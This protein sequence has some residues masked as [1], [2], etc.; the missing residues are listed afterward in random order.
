MRNKGGK[1]E[2]HA[3]S[4]VPYSHDIVRHDKKT[5]AFPFALFGN[6]FPQV[7]TKVYHDDND[8]KG[9]VVVVVVT[10]GWLEQ[11]SCGDCVPSWFQ[12]L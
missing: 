2:G 3:V 6:D 8:S 7:S 9:L 12:D 1:N 11:G 10:V 5:R 4:V